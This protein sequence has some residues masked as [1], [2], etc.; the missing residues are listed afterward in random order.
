MFVKTAF[1]QR[2][3]VWGLDS[4]SNTHQRTCW[5]TLLLILHFSPLS[6][7][8]NT[9]EESSVELED[10]GDVYRKWQNSFSWVKEVNGAASDMVEP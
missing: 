8:E 1:G 6:R 7:L 4:A 3:P 5:V 10:E 2:P 9:E